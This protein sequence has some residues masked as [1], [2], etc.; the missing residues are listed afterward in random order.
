MSKLLRIACTFLLTELGVH[1][2]NQTGI[3]RMLSEHAALGSFSAYRAHI[4][5][6]LLCQSNFRGRVEVDNG[7]KGQVIFRVNL[8]RL[9]YS[10]GQLQ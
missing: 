7:F 2:K 10:F 1:F 6:N 3:K 4:A 5:D 9:D 8:V